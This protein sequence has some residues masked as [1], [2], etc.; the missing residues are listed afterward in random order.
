MRNAQCPRIELQMIL[1][2][3]K[4]QSFN[5]RRLYV[6]NAGTIENAAST[7][8]VLVVLAGTTGL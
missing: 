3:E 1:Q 6:V 4:V 5:P 2:Y 7:V 8:H